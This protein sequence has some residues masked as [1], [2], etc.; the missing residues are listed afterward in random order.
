MFNASFHA[1]CRI[2]GCPPCPAAW[3]CRRDTVTQ[4]YETCAM[5]HA[6]RWAPSAGAARTRRCRAFRAHARAPDRFEAVRRTGASPPQRC[7]DGAPWRCSAACVCAR[8]RV[9]ACVCAC[10]CV[11]VCRPR[12]QLVA[13]VLNHLASVAWAQ[14]RT[15]EHAGGR[16]SQYSPVLAVLAGTHAGTHAAHSPAAQARRRTALH[17]VSLALRVSI[18]RFAIGS[19]SARWLR[20]VGVC[21]RACVRVRHS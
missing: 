11:C 1:R 15:V 6:V 10:A 19:A 21:V 18:V 9:C 12:S 3:R 7:C 8:C 20:G 5:A 2:L 4:T 16:Y 14:V 13:T 17:F